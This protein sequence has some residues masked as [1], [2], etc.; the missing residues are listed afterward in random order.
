M[1]INTKANR[2]TSAFANKAKYQNFRN[3]AL[4]IPA[5][6]LVEQYSCFRKNFK[7][8][9]LESQWMILAK[10]SNFVSGAYDNRGGGRRWPCCQVLS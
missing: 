3:S 10:I 1:Q 2:P 9:H 5:I 8:E 6:S 7:W 4:Q